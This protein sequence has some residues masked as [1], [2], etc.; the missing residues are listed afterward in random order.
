M[1]SISHF[2]QSSISLEVDG[3]NSHQPLPLLTLRL[4]N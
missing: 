3:G 1:M 4:A 2:D